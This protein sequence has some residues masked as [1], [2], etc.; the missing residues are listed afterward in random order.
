MTHSFSKPESSPLVA[1]KT[2]PMP[3]RESGRSSKYLP[4]TFG[5]SGVVPMRL[6]VA[7]S[8]NNRSMIRLLAPHVNG[9]VDRRMQRSARTCNGSLAVLLGLPLVCAGCPEDASL[10]IRISA[11]ADPE[12]SPLDDRLSLV[13]LQVTGPSIT[14]QIQSR[15]VVRGEPLDLGEVP[16]ADGLSL[17]LAASDAAGRLL[18]FGRTEAPVDVSLGVD[19]EIEVRLR[20][21]FA[22][23]IGGPQLTA[24][25]TTFDITQPNYRRDLAGTGA[26]SAVAVPPDGRDIVVVEGT[27][28]RLLDTATHQPVAGGAA[29]TLTPGTTDA[30]VSPDSAWL[31]VAHA[32]GVSLVRLADL[33]AGSAS[34][35][36][37]PVGNAG[38]IA[39][40][41]NTA[42]VLVDAIGDDCPAQAP[43]SSLVRIDLAAGSAG[44]LTSMGVQIADL[45]A[46]TLTGTVLAALPCANKVQRLSDDAGTP[47][48]SDVLDLPR[49]G[50]VAAVGGRAWALGAIDGNGTA[51]L[52]LATIEL[53]DPAMPSATIPLPV[54][55]ELASSD[56]FDL[57]GVP[58]QSAEVR[59]GADQV[60]PIDLAV[61]P[62]GSRLAVLWNGS[63]ETVAFGTNPFGGPLISGLTLTTSEYQLL[64][65]ATAAPLQRLRTRCQGEVKGD[66]LIKSFAC[67]QSPGQDIVL[68][69][70]YA[71]THIAV[72]FGER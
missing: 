16:I 72:L 48:L 39:V 6:C 2:S 53:A 55:E 46:D 13:T 70:D 10:R 35:T 62:D 45:A 50:A 37:L 47:T 58:G 67:V 14:T 38:A 27:Q 3:P 61:L 41:G 51:H 42:W 20:R 65:A 8:I 15:P 18:G 57:G 49:A 43:S 40:S 44:D 17:T 30:M 7:E 24:I 26:A 33:R 28:V 1:R 32:T 63:Y 11:P 59:M 21:P 4:K 22:Y 34:P 31:I 19:A 60:R 52:V 36:F 23:M 69:D 12:L 29:A 54:P 56:D 64:D 68:G 66:G 5:I 71:P 25:D 9:S